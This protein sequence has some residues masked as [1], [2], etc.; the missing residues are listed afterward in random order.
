MIR[1]ATR[2]FILALA[3]AVLAGCAQEQAA[4]TATSEKEPPK[5][6]DMVSGP[7]KA[8]DG[9]TV[10]IN[11]KSIDLWGVEAPN[12]DNSDG[13]YS[14]AALDRFIGENG[15]LVCITKAKRK[16]GRVLAICSNNRVGDV[17]R[18][19][20]L[21]GWAVVNRRD[22]RNMDVDAALS[23]VYERTEQRARQTRAGLWTNY[24]L[25]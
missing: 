8:E 19:L 3:F 16:R 9:D 22:K 7:A 18:A 23:G 2:K 12:L 25:K 11:G 24:P 14:R 20:L 4:T 13:W 21:N 1:G 5:R 6:K 15:E 17:G 10:I